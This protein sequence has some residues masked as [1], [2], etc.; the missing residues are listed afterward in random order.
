[1]IPA[2]GA[3]AEKI[4]FAPSGVRTYTYDP[5]VTL[6][7]HAKGL[8]VIGMLEATVKYPW[9]DWSRTWIMALPVAPPEA[10]VTSVVAPMEMMPPGV[11]IV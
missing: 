5:A 4:G 10:K 8:D 2:Y 7:V 1:M 3:Q 6:T 9:V 11:L